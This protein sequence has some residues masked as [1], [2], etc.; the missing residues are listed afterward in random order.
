MP[1]PFGNEV[2][3]EMTRKTGGR[4]VDRTNA[5][6]M[7]VPTMFGE[8]SSYYAIAFRTIFSMD[9]KLRRLH[10]EVKR[11]DSGPARRISGLF[12][13]PGNP[14]LRGSMRAPIHREQAACAHPTD[15]TSLLL[16]RS[17]LDSATPGGRRA[18]QPSEITAQAP[19]PTR[20][21]SVVLDSASSG[22]PWT[23]ER[24]RSLARA[25]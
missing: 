9:G 20:K 25:R 10:V 19:H 6:E 21:W 1:S 15:W 24:T 16:G 3:H 18:G 14:P 5:P 13:A 17:S 22:V 12:L 8:L 4:L 11:P 23:R 2:V 7:E